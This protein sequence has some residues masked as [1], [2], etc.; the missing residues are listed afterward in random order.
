MP[1]VPVHTPSVRISPGEVSLR[2]RTGEGVGAVVGEA[3]LAVAKFLQARKQSQ[4][5]EQAEADAFQLSGLQLD[6]Q[7]QLANLTRKFDEQPGDLATFGD[8]FD[9]EAGA[10][11]DRVAGG[12]RTADIQQ[13]LNLKGASLVLPMSVA[14]RASGRARMQDAALTNL[15]DLMDGS[16]DSFADAPTQEARAVVKA[17]VFDAINAQKEIGYLT[18]GQAGSLEDQIAERMDTNLVENLLVDDPAL[19]NQMLS[20]AANT[21]PGITPENR[22]KLQKRGRSALEV[23]RREAVVARLDTVDAAL[24]SAALPGFDPVRDDF[25]FEA[26]TSVNDAALKSGDIDQLQHVRRQVNIER[27]KQ[28]QVVAIEMFGELMR[29]ATGATDAQRVTDPVYMQGAEGMWADLPKPEDADERAKLARDFVGA[30]GVVPQ[31]LAR[32]TE[33]SLVAGDPE[34]RVQASALLEGIASV[35]GGADSIRRSVISADAVKSSEFVNALRDFGLPPSVITER[36]EEAASL[37]PRDI[38]TRSAAYVETVK[39]GPDSNADFLANTLIQ[40]DRTTF[41]TVANLVALGLPRNIGNLLQVNS[42]NPGDVESLSSEMLA[43]FEFFVRENYTLTNNLAQARSISLSDVQRVWSATGING[44]AEFMRNPPESQLGVTTQG[45]QAQ[46]IEDVREL[47][48][49][50]SGHTLPIYR[51][52]MGAGWVSFL[53]GELASIV[54][55]AKD[56]LALTL[57]SEG[58]DTSGVGA[59]VFEFDPSRI[60]VQAD[61][62]TARTRAGLSYTVFVQNTDDQTW[63]EVKRWDPAKGSDGE[64]VDWRWF[65]DASRSRIARL[66]TAAGIATPELLPSDEEQAQRLFEARRGGGLEALIVHAPE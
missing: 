48:V 36:L 55:S 9:T 50:P 32:S 5:R 66:K 61:S 14:A 39:T 38:A 26:A 7:R 23:V 34:E 35:R 27:R 30:I 57:D 65:P 29:A 56:P 43:D 21:L 8:R 45:A 60:V 40:S 10:I 41:G 63:T 51:E 28:G 44:R 13:R 59:D 18:E 11:V 54:T 3:G 46:L 58:V 19:A 52:D 17:N 33:R 53:A 2:D 12:A 31:A 49:G 62:R 6:M 47:T 42:V 16:V 20:D 25:N 64:W 22:L 37:S 15:G 24:A 4:Q 1:R